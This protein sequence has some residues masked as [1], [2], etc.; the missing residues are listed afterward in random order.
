MFKATIT[1]NLDQLQRKFAGKADALK[2]GISG[3]IAKS[4]LLVERQSKIR[5]PVDTGRLRSSIYSDI[6]PMRAT[7]QPNTNYA[8]FVHE[9]TKRMKSRP[10]M[11]EGYVAAYREIIQNFGDAVEKAIKK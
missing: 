1:P 5:T 8:V 4:A 3:A 2:K 11:K 6:A 9:G 10:Y 7:I